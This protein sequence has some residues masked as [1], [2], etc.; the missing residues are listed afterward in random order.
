M[1]IFEAHMRFFDIPGQQTLKDQLSRSL[2]E[3]RV[4]HALLFHGPEG[5]AGLPL[6]MAFAQFIQCTNPGEYDSC[7]ECPSC[8]KAE[9]MIHP[10]I[11][12]VFPVIKGVKIDLDSDSNKKEKDPISDN[13]IVSWRSYLQAFPYPSMKTW[14]QALDV[15]NK[16][17]SIYTAEASS[18][19]KKMSLKAFESDY[20]VVILWLPE[21][22]NS[23]LANKLLKI[24]EEPPVKTVFLLVSQQPDQ[25]LPTILS[26]TQLIRISGFSDEEIHDILLRY[27]PDQQ[28]L[29]R[30]IIPLAAGNAVAAVTLL[31]QD[32]QVLFNRENFIQLMRMS[33]NYSK[34]VPDILNWVGVIGKIGRENQKSFLDYCLNE[35]RQNYLVNN[36]LQSL[37]RMNQEEMEFSVRFN[38]FIHT[39]NIESLLGIFS[40]AGW[41]IEMNANPRILFLDLS[42]ELYRALR[43]K[44]AS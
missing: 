14:A 24:I 22:M 20:K 32:E 19:L 25:I 15:E 42:Y 41:Q 38:R 2:K 18:L 9:Q 44:P 21:R 36:G 39:E 10:D 35:V 34:T 37:T 13:F 11:H 27:Y 16:Q 30:Q 12:F 40:K 43:T 31:N 29:F 28:D 23:T 26:R 1:N 5:N 3:S 17:G 4:S 8:R 7:G 6:A 33:Y